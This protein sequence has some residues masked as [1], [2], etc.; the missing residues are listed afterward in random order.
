KACVGKLVCRRASSP[1]LAGRSSAAGHSGE[2][3]FAPPYLRRSAI[4]LSFRSA[5]PISCHSEVLRRGICFPKKP[6]TGVPLLLRL[7][8]QAGGFRGP[9]GPSPRHAP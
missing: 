6:H 9:K 1:V 4:F 8:S 7:N 3:A 5:S 2:A